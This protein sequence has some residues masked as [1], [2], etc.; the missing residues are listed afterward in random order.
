MDIPFEYY[1]IALSVVVG[2]VMQILKHTV[3]YVRF[4]PHFLLVAL[5]IEITAWRLWTEGL[6][7]AALYNF[8][9]TVAFGFY[10][11]LIRQVVF[12]KKA[13]KVIKWVMY[14]YLA[15]ALINILF[16]QKINTFHTFTY[17]LG[18]FLIVVISM[19]YFYQLFQLPHSIN[20][21]REPAF[22]IVSGLLFYYLCTLPLLGALNYLY[23]LPGVSPRSLEQITMILNVL[24]YSLFTI[25]FLCRASFRKS[26][27]SS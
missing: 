20:L 25:S 13:K 3:H 4:F 6:Q 19:Y 21:A 23:T 18:C 11:D 5:I 14:I 9:S 16:I 12:S 10:L 15:S 8:F 7:N 1:F 24:L 26:M 22:W 2:F 27:L 17:S